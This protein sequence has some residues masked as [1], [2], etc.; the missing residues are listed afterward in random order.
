MKIPKT[1]LRWKGA[2]AR[3]AKAPL[4]V[5]ENSDAHPTYLEEP[6]YRARG[7]GS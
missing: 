6:T 4:I 3:S 5:L 1:G 2:R 7:A